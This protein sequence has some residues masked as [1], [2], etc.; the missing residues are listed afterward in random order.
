MATPFFMK[1]QTSISIIYYLLLCVIIPSCKGQTYRSPSGAME[2]TIMVGETFTM[3]PADEFKNNDIVVFRLWTRPVFHR[4]GEDST[5]YRWEDRVFRLV[6]QSGDVMTIKDRDLYVNDKLIPLPLTAK[7]DYEIL[8]K[9]YIEFPGKNE[10]DVSMVGR[11]GGDT[12]I[13]YAM[14]TVSEIESY[15]NPNIV[16][17]RKRIGTD[18]GAGQ[19]MPAKPSA[20]LLWTT[21]YYGPLSIPSPGETITID[22]DNYVLYQNLPDVQ[23][24]QYIIKEKLYFTMGD[25][26]HQAMD[27]RYIGF[28]S[29]SNMKGIVKK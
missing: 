13:Y 19:I 17:I 7:A 24:G 25:N 11:Y 28:I 18:R 15:K 29:Y 10:Y 12:L 6:A 23:K 9:G 14:A 3:T 8:T 21:D 26:R 1:P 27:S 22:E 4:P 5:K 16:R 2:N 20:D